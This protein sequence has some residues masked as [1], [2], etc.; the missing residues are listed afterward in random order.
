MIAARELKPAGFVSI[1]GTSVRANKLLRGQLAHSLSPEL[2]ARALPVLK[3][4]EQG[5]T[6][7][8]VPSELWFEFRPSVQPYL[9]SWFQI[10][11]IEEMRKVPCPSLVVQGTTDIQV[12]PE[13][14]QALADAGSQATLR[15]ID[16]MNHIMKRVPADRPQQLASYN[17]PKLPLA[18]ELVD[19]VCGFIHSTE[20]KQGDGRSS[21][22]R[23]RS[24]G[25]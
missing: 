25:D 9:V 8:Q 13:Q 12:P 22:G 6:T 17:N 20:Q 24:G 21:D 5:E 19:A 11:P 4:L 3:K 15:T 23:A 2:S 10:D 14:A 1:S 7:Q 16:G 18:K